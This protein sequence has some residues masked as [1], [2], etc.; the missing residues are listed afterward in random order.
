MYVLGLS[1]ENGSLGIVDQEKALE[2]Y[3]KAADAGHEKAKNIV[4]SM[5]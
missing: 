1:Y 4:E 3:Q 5:K 2:W